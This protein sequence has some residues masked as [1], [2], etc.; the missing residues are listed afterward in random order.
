MLRSS[1]ATSLKS[2]AP[3]LFDNNLRYGTYILYLIMPDVLTNT[4]LKFVLNFE[5][6]SCLML[7]KW[8]KINLSPSTNIS[9]FILLIF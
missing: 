3:S 6:V 4:L 5:P 1:F 9:L 2:S 7:A 8:K